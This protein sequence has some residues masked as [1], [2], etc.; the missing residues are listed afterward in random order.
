MDYSYPLLCA[1][2]RNPARIAL[3]GPG[4]NVS[5]AE[6]EDRIAAMAGGFVATGIGG[7]AVGVMMSN[8]PAVVVVLMALARANCIAVPINTRLTAKE[9]SVIVVDAAVERIVADDAQAERA[10]RLLGSDGGVIAVTGSPFAGDTLT[11]LA[12]RGTPVKPCADSDGDDR[13]ATVTYT[14]G[15]TGTPKGVQR[16]HRANTW[17][18]VNS[19]LGSP[20]D[21]NDVELFNL[22]AFGIGFVHFVLPALIGGATVVLD[23]AFD[24]VRVWQLIERHR[25]TRTFLAPTMISAM[26]SVPAEQRSD[27]S[28]L[29]TIYT[30]YAFPSRLRAAALQE[31]GDVFVYM[32]GLTEAQLTCAVADQFRSDPTNVGVPMGVARIGAFDEDGNKVGPNS[33]GEIGFSG[34]STMTGYHQRPD[35]TAAVVRGEWVMTGDLGTVDDNGHLRYVG[36]LKEIIKT[37]GFSVDPFEVEE[38]ILEL[39]TVSE[40]AVVGVADDHW[41]E[42]IVAFAVTSGTDLGVDEVREFCRDKISGFKA[43]KALFNVEELPKNATGK[44][45]RGRLRGLAASLYPTG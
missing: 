18:A 43:P 35:E 23:E 33:V 6:L 39:P 38:V 24:A 22:P 21:S 8:T 3:I 16:T 45:D 15:T 26:L 31:F 1:C 20:R 17:N 13:I 11:A 36:R 37:G 2:E 19:A 9:Q 4:E 28:S 34:P 32:Y 12:G 41:G 27:T 29:T 7:S 40:V 14:S 25:V 10:G 30:A 44:I 42:A 5:F